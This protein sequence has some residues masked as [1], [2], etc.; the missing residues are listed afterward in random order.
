MLNRGYYSTPFEMYLEG[1]AYPEL[2]LE[3]KMYQNQTY[4]SI[5]SAFTSLG[6]WAGIIIPAILVWGILW[7][8]LQ[9]EFHVPEN[10]D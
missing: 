8:Q 7:Y 6:F 4:L 9:R 5:Y 1:L 3:S 10:D 2:M